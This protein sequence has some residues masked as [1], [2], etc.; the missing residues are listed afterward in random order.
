MI[1]DRKREIGV[2]NA[3]GK[4]RVKLIRK[5]KAK[6]VASFALDFEIFCVKNNYF[7]FIFILLFR[8]AAV[9]ATVQDLQ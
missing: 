6:L 9:C 3:L 1:W 4:F 2:K 8:R 7:Y 5:W